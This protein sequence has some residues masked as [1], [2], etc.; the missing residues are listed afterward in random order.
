VPNAE[1]VHDEDT[2]CTERYAVTFA[3]EETPPVRGFWSLTLYNQHHFFNPKGIKR[4]FVGTKTKSF[5]YGSLT[6]SVQADPPPEA[7]RGNWLPAPM[8]EDFS[9]CV[10]SYWPAVVRTN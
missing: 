3:K 4:Y 1:A 5:K 2:E 7:Q 9:L 10:R 6:I 8:G